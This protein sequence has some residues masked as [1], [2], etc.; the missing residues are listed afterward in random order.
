VGLRRLAA[1]AYTLAPGGI[2][3]LQALKTTK[4]AM[5]H[6]THASR[7]A[8]PQGVCRCWYQGK[9]VLPQA[10]PYGKGGDDTVGMAADADVDLP[11]PVV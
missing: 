3:E 8:L 1:L 9:S 4:M 2:V 7:G 5:A 6:P 10:R 11:E